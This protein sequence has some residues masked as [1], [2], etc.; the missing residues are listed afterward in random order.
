MG[1]MAMAGKKY[2]PQ[3]QAI[4]P[5]PQTTPVQDDGEKIYSTF[6]PIDDTTSTG[7]QTDF[8]VCYVIFSYVVGF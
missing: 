1:N 8:P 6:K 5:P 3:T 4:V 2:I 7:K